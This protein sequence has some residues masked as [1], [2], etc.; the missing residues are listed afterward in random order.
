MKNQAKRDSRKARQEA[1]KKF[2]AEKR[3]AH[4]EELCDKWGAILVNGQWEPLEGEDY[5]Y[6]DE[7]EGQKVNRDF[8]F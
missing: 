5:G 1:K 4:H 7:F 2:L 6:S 8:D 3:Q